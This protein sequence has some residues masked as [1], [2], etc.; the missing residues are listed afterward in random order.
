M[1]IKLLISFTSIISLILLSFTSV[2]SNL[3]DTS[4]CLKKVD[5]KWGDV[6]I[7]CVE[8]KN[9]KRVYDDTYK[10]FLVNTCTEKIE[11]KLAFQESDGSW[12]C[13]EPK[14]VAPNDTI[15][16]FA[17]KSTKGKYLSWVRAVNDRETTF[18]TDKEINDQYKD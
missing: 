15:V 12:R 3:M 10:A 17:C 6:C 14:V 1:K 13:F 8:Y 9:G 4:N 16:G 5:S 7:D 11:V 18:P 2:H